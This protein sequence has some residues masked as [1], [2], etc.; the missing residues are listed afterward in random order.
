MRLRFFEMLGETFAQSHVGH[1]L[2]EARQC[3]EELR[4]TIIEGIQLDDVQVLERDKVCIHGM[5]PESSIVTFK[6]GESCSI[7]LER[8]IGKAPRDNG[9]SALAQRRSYLLNRN[10]RVDFQGSSSSL[11]K[12]LETGR[13]AKTPGSLP[14][15]AASTCSRFL[16]LSVTLRSSCCPISIFVSC[17]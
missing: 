17:F 2:N 6:E 13:A 11:T 7:L 16:S 14:S 4:L 1:S 10:K 12:V 5:A 15:I 8:R 3:L 9:E